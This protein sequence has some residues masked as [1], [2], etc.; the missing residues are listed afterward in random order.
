MLLGDEDPKPVE[1]IGSAGKAAGLLLCEHAGREIPKSLQSLG[2]QHDA[3]TAHIAYDIGAEATAKLI[4]KAL[5]VTLVLQRY[6]RLVIDCNRPPEAPDS[7]PGVSHG[8]VIPGN[9]QLSRTDRDQRITE[10]FNPLDNTLT[11]HF[12]NAPVQWAFSIHSFTPELNGTPRPWDLGLLYQQ[13]TQTSNKMASYASTHYP[14]ITVGLNE[15]YQI[16]NTSDWFIPQHA[17]KHRV[18]NCL[19][20]IRNDLISTKAG[21]QKWSAI[22]T[23]LIRHAVTDN[24]NA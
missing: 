7:I 3:L 10:I 12:N 16:D 8:T 21:Q 22:V 19:I 2:L 14:Q 11:A 24:A 13:D 17:E 5:D 1:V 18:Q 4:A 9:S 15:P 6:S 23:D 20:E